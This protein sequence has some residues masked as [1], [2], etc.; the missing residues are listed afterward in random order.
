M[1]L[2]DALHTVNYWNIRIKEEFFAWSSNVWTVDWIL[3]DAWYGSLDPGSGTPLPVSITFKTLGDPPKR[4][5]EVAAFGLGD[6]NYEHPLPG[7]NDPYWLYG[8]DP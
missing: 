4:Y 2:W 7:T 1:Q 5:L 3:S 6:H 8:T